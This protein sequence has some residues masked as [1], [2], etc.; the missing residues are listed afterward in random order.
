MTAPL[1]T[2]LIGFGGIAH[3]LAADARMAKWFP[4]ATHVQAIN[5]S[6]H[7][8]LS[9]VIDPD[10]AARAIA[11]SDW[12][13]EAFENIQ[14]AA[15]LDPDVVVFA[16]PPG[17]RASA[18]ATFPSLKGVIVEKPLGGED[19]QRLIKTCHT[20]DIPV[21]VNYWRRG[22]A[23]L[24]ALAAGDLEVRIGTIQAGHALYGN[25]LANNGSH[26]V[27]MIR[28]LTGEPVWVQALG[29]AEPVDQT[30]IANDI[31]VAFALGLGNG[32]CLTAHPVEFTHY[33]EVSLDLWGTQGRLSFMQETLDIRHFKRAPNRGLDDAFEIASD[34]G[35]LL[36]STV[37]SAL[38]NL[39]ENLSAA[40]HGKASSLSTGASALRTET[41]IEHIQLS[42]NQRGERLNIPADVS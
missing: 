15:A 21:Q 16:T 35:T 1:K 30:P 29:N 13:T 33:R 42:A 39:Y 38:P 6:P 26:L 40:I 11:A 17:E 34:A 7:F 25:G 22:D 31:H 18:L 3:G 36:P 28:M 8:Q 2:L 14:A 12:S 37:A 20:R 23:T 41:I 19:G 27:D 24:Q 9:G 10:P 32:T 4:T 5:E